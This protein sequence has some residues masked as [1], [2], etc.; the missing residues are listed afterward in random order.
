[1]VI[2]M[3]PTDLPRVTEIAIDVR[4][5]GFTAL[6]AIACALF[7]GLV[8]LLRY[9]VG[10][11]A[12]RLR[13]GGAH[14]AAGSRTTHRLRNGL[15]V[16]QMALALVLLI[17]SGLMFRSFRALRSVD[18]GF[19]TEGV[20]T[21][22][23]SVPS[24]EVP[25]GLTA[26][27]FYRQLGERLAAQVGVESVGFAQFT[28]L[29]GA[30]SFF[31][32]EVEDQPRGPNELPVMAS[33]NRIEPGYLEAMGIELLEGRTLEP[34]DGA[35]GARSVIVSRSFADHWWPNTSPLGR[36]MRFGF[37][38]EEWF[39]IVGVVEDA[40]YESL[41][42]VPEEMVYWPATVGAAWSPQPTR[43]MDVVIRT[44][45]DPLGLVP[46]LQREVSALNPRIP[47]SDPRTME[48]VFADA[49]ARTSF[50][51]ALLGAASTI[52]LLLGLVGIYGVISYI[53]AQRTREIGVR[54]A[55]GA[56][57]STVRA[58]VVRQALVLAS[59]GAGIG[60]VVA[61]ALSSVMASLLY[62]VSATDPL[63]YLTVAAALVAVSLAAGWIPA[64]RAAGVDP[65]RALRAE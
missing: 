58:M 55:L 19:A 37:P 62:G 64:S 31:S 28:P 52:A 10:D 53:V 3:V 54:M 15:V 23:L 39:Q 45:G 30:M 48:R 6:I 60:L 21:A 29:R 59:L 4:V 42:A 44:T 51:V 43:A 20:L 34:G 9:G 22:R 18:P 7:F 27:A 16:T 61:A 36:R 40:H 1:V 2:G 33:N 65:S 38:D 50:T 32:I 17:A 25:D 11:L 47:V 13:E 12:T 24:G 63:T 35:E 56:T 14:G 49:T 41:E 46:V 8:P 5:L 26:A 57:A